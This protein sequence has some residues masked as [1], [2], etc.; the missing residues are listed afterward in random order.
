[1]LS[2][3]NWLL[4]EWA[5]PD[6]PLLQYELAQTRGKG[7]RFGLKLQLVLL[8]LLI[9]GS[10]LLYAAATRSPQSAANLTGVFWRSVYYPAL[11]LQVIT[12]IMAFALGAAAVGSER[13]RKTWDHLRVTE[14]GAGVALRARWAGILY[15]L[16]API[17]LILL[18]RLI[19]VGGIVYD[20][21]AFGGLY[22]AMLGAQATPPLPWRLDL[23]LIA[24][25]VLLNLLLPLAAIATVAALGILISVA[26]KERVY[27]AIIQILV[28]LAQLIASLAGALAIAQTI[29]RDAPGADD[30]S[31]ALFFGYSAFGDLG[32]LLAQLGS[33]GEVWNRVPN[34][35][36][37]IVCLMVILVALGAAADGMMWL[38]GGLS[39]SR[40]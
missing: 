16:R 32:L 29:A 30:W 21:T 31:Y 18:I 35:A 28:V 39:E 8:S 20:L 2:V 27:A 5:Q 24:L 14:F 19:L 25:A 36:T 4:P 9:G 1:M 22:P 10:A 33:L 6:H 12:L 23:L 38:A 15:R 7:G 17:L 13:S 40:G 37:I 11:A 3:W 26:V 34:G